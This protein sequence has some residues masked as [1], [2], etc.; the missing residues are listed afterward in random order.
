MKKGGNTVRIKYAC[1]VTLMIL[2]ITACLVL[3]SCE[4]PVS[5]E[6]VG[7]YYLYENG[8]K[9]DIWIEF[10][11]NRTSWRDSYG[12]KGS[13]K[14]GST[15]YRLYTDDESLLY[16][17]SVNNGI[18][19]F[20][21]VEDAE[22]NLFKTRDFYSEKA[23]TN[24]VKDSREYDIKRVAFSVA[25]HE[26]VNAVNIYNRVGAS[27]DV[28][29]YPLFEELVEA[30]SRYFISDG[31]LYLNYVI[32]DCSETQDIINR[33]TSSDDTSPIAVKDEEGNIVLTA[34]DIYMGNVRDLYY[35]GEQPTVKFSCYSEKIN[36]LY[37]QNPNAK[38]SLYV[39]GEFIKEL[40]TEEQNGKI[41]LKEF[42][43]VGRDAGILRKSVEFHLLSLNLTLVK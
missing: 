15:G 2:L 16:D 6:D 40:P 9:S 23:S 8:V 34:S 20:Y 14:G 33:L 13:V 42:E 32:K 31:T 1:I 29:G 39:F 35:G 26:E 28:Y 18:F 27:F 17:G 24:T 3:C 11:S 10:K 7:K 19:S 21:Y 22:N 41:Q 12:N 5:R 38:L 25:L 43:Y 37:Y 30:N 4:V 36:E